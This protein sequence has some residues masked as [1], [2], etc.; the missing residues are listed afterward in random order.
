MSVVD[1]R[2]KSLFDSLKVTLAAIRGELDATVNPICPI[3][4]EVVCPARDATAYEVAY[5]Q[6]GIGIESN[7]GSYIANILAG[8]A[9]LLRRMGSADQ[10][11]TGRNDTNARICG[12]QG[13][14]C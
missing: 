8:A 9:E 2:S 1:V 10:M 13:R 14:D 7:P 3:L 5:G 6:L 4:D 12:G 11:E